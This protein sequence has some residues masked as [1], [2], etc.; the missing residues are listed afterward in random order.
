MTFMSV[1]MA[2]MLVMLSSFRKLYTLTENVF[3]FFAAGLWCEIL[4]KEVLQGVLW[5]IQIMPETDISGLN[6][7][8]DEL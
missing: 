5:L 2:V 3:L 7:L 4:R 1:M 8:P 6:L